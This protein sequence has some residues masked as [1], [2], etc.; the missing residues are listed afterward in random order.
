MYVQEYL[1]PPRDLNVLSELFK[2]TG[3]VYVEVEPLYALVFRYNQS[4]TLLWVEAD[5]PCDGA[6][7]LSVQT[8]NVTVFPANES[9]L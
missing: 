5:P 9:L 2:L 7:G 1:F 6:I 8:E 3:V 4:P